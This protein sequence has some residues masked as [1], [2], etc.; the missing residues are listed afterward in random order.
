LLIVVSLVAAAVVAAIG[1]ERVNAA[2]VQTAPD[3]YTNPGVIGTSPF[4]IKVGDKYYQYVDGITYGRIPIVESTD[5]DTWTWPNAQSALTA[6]SYSW[7]QPEPW[8]FT[9]PSVAHIPSNPENHRFV[10]YF[11]GSHKGGPGHPVGQRCIGVATSGSPAG[12][13]VEYAPVGQTPQPLVCPDNGSSTTITAEAKDASP[14]PLAG[15]LNIRTLVYQMTGTSAGI[16]ARKL[17]PSGLA[18][19]PA[20][21]ASR[22]FTAPDR[23][24]AGHNLW[25]N[26]VVERPT[27]TVGPDGQA[28]LFFS[29]QDASTGRQAV[30]RVKCVTYGSLAPCVP[31]QSGLPLGV[32]PANG[33]RWFGSS[34]QVANPGRAHVFSDGNQAW[35]AYQASPASDC[36]GTTCANTRTYLDKVCFAGN[37]P[38]TNAPTTGAQARN[39]SAPCEQDVPSDW[40]A[41]VGQHLHHVGGGW[42]ELD[43]A[44]PGMTLR[45]VVHT[46]SGGTALRVRITNR[47]GTEPLRIDQATVAVSG[48]RQGAASTTAGPIKPLTFGGRAGVQVPIGSE[49]VSDAIRFDSPIPSGHDVAISLFIPQ[50]AGPADL[51]IVGNETSFQAPGNQT[52]ATSLTSATAGIGTIGVAAVDLLTPNPQGTV[53]VLGDSITDGFGDAPILDTADDTDPNTTANWTDVLYTRLAAAGRGRTGVVNQ[54]LVGGRLGPASAGESGLERLDRDVLAQTGIRTMIVELGNNDVRGRAGLTADQLTSEFQA[55]VQRAH[56][57]GVRVVGMTILPIWFPTGSGG[58][59]TFDGTT[60]NEAQEEIRTTVNQRMIDG[61]IPF[62]AVVRLDQVYGDKVDPR[63]LDLAMVGDDCVHPGE[64]GR[65]SIAAAVDLAAL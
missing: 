32:H 36:A 54:G 18:V 9:A 7:A 47:V 20:T 28:W 51:W 8:K 15:A 6:P 38:R 58:N 24:A 25:L 17:L 62:D 52:G 10:L 53:V 37:Q 4:V 39:P 45:Q 61:T 42:G 2:P 26:G 21:S 33:G 65:S 30:G 63:K 14:T 44:S 35:I 46:T 55:L 23:P 56:A 49:V 19:D 31:Y 64:L 3:G 29:G 22:I 5:L 43:V 60:L 48:Q 11:T 27:V 40:Q 59:C 41:A 16:H 57:A 1:P 13:F 34:D 12:P 50:H